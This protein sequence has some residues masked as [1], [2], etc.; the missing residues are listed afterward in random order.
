LGKTSQTFPRQKKRK[1]PRPIC[2][3]FAPTRG[4]LGFLAHGCR[5]GILDSAADLVEREPDERREVA[6][7]V[8]RGPAAFADRSRAREA[9]LEKLAID[10]GKGQRLAQH[11][12]PVGRP[13]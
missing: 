9:V 10:G 3:E 8:S 13:E 6:N 7:N 5:D 12:E 2:S 1:K 4:I 11:S